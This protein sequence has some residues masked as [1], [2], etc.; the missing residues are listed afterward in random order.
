MSK[1]KAYKSKHFSI[2]LIF[3]IAGLLSFFVTEKVSSEYFKSVISNIGSAVFISGIFSLI[4]QYILKIDLV[5]LILEKL[6]LKQS[7]DTTGIEEVFF[8]IGDIDYSYYL[9]KASKNIDIVHI[10]GRSWTNANVDELTEKYLNSNCNIRVILLSPDSL[11]IPGLAG[12][13][14]ITEDDLKG[15]IIDV[16]KMWKY[17]RD[18]R[19]GQ[20]RRRTQSCLK[21]YYHTGQPTNSFY[22]IDDRIICVQ[23]KVT[24]GRTTKLPSFILSNTNKQQDLYTV[25]KE[26]IEQ[27]IK[28]SKELDLD[29]I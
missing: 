19:C 14:S 8:G 29:T 27:L 13:Y 16:A 28:E 11:F 5:E 24:K 12:H 23:S 25:Y 15:R 2:A 18:K 21:V 10:Y 3:V 20:R 7:I 1:N 22:R 6:K 9:K 17:I 26:E 4:D